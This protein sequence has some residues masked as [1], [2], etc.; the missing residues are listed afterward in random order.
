VES[1]KDDLRKRGR[2]D[3]AAVFARGEGLWWSEHGVYF[4]AT[5]GGPTRNGQVWRLSPGK[6]DTLD[7][8]VEADGESL[9][10]PDNL[11]VAPWGDLIACED[12]VDLVQRTA[13]H[14]VGIHRDGRTYQFARNARDGTELAGACFAPDGRTL[15]VNLYAPGATLAISGPFPG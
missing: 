1:P 4:T 11:C 13:Q 14:L 15:F 7:L 8:I 6:P 9:E 10:N 5:N 2:R 3:G 12:H